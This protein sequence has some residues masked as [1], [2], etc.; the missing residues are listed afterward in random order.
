M[1]IATSF[2]LLAATGCVPVLVTPGGPDDWDWD[3]PENSWFLDAPPEG[4]V[5]EGFQP[6][7][8]IPDFR[9]F[10]QF[11]DEV[12]LWQFH[13]Q[14]IVLDVSTMWCGPCRELAEEAEE[15]F[16]AYADDGV[17]YLDVLAENLL[18]DPP[19]LADLNLWVGEY[20]LTFP[21]VSDPEG[22]WSNPAVPLG[23]YP[24]VLVI[25]RDLEV[26]EKVDPPSD[27]NIRAAVEELLE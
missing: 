11:D 3:P 25:D 23:Q 7:E 1:R 26:Y 18:G 8:V 15:T 20:G 13:T 9:L 4:L 16:Q 14:V 5:S 21:V 27:A 12:S 24:V 19:S 2:A 6:G 10:D 22:A 17:I